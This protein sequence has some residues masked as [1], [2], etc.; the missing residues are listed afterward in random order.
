MKIALFTDTF[1][2]QV[3]GVSLTLQRWAEHMERRQV[4]TRIFVPRCTQED[5][6]APG[7]L[8][9]LSVPLF[10]YPEHRLSFPN[11]FFIRRELREF[12]PDLIHVTTPFN[13]GLMGLHIAKKEGI[14]LVA[15][16]HTHFDR[17]L[18]YY[19][20]Q[21]LSSWIW[22]YMRWFHESCELLLA[23]SDET[24]QLLENKG[25]PRLDLWRRGVDT[26]LF[27]PS[28]ANHAFRRRYHI[29]G[30]HVLLYVGRMAPEKDLDVL[31]GAMKKLPG[32][33]RD[34]V[35]WVLV[36]DGPMRE[37]LEAEKLPHIT[38][39]G[40]LR[41]EALAEAYAS[42]DAFVFPSTTET[43]GNV[44]LESLAAGTP[45]V[46][47]RAGGVKEIVEHGRTGWFASPRSVDGLVE[48]I[49]H[50]LGNSERLRWMGKEARRMALEQSWDQIFDRLLF[51]Y[52]AIVERKT[53]RHAHAG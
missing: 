14:P 24:K 34:Q 31:A 10:F 44:V 35:H 2:P 22:N 43:F 28:R 49:C 36:G 53:A 39:T 23:P 3:N 50:L 51:R 15:S 19:R 38:F 20:L 33:F 45:A 18:Q 37:E 26:E 4:E 8:R 17:Y 25:L 9:S 52:E 6:E 47:A 13:M 5:P 7:V 32:S 41:G 46:V 29:E 16:Y 48:G 12:R 1:P 11:P 42:A 40:T 30:Q 21:F 27:C